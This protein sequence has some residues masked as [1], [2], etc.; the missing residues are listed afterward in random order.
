VI[1]RALTGFGAP[2]A[3]RVTAGS[4]E[5]NEIFAAALRAVMG[6]A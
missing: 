2:A 5:E 6:S 1:V 3:I 4:D